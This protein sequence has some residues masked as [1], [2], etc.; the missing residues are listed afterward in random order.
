MFLSKG[1]DSTWRR[2]CRGQMIMEYAIMFVV[3]VVVIFYAATHVIKPA[4]NRF[5]NASGEI[6]DNVTNEI[7]SRF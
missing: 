7:Q 5:F 3:I 2:G 1:K 4:V 6:L